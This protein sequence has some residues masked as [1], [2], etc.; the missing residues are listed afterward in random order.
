MR[1]G[2]LNVC[3]RCRRGHSARLPCGIPSLTR[4]SRGSQQGQLT[5]EWSVR[6]LVLRRRGT[7]RDVL[8]EERLD[9]LCEL[10][11]AAERAM[12]ALPIE[13]EEVLRLGEYCEELRRRVQMEQ[14]WKS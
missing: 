3:P 10:I 14:V 4:M 2:G 7:S 13:S 5:K 1:G 8:Q 11:A 9:N 6:P 12:R